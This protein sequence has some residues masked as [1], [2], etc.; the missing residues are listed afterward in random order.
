M[1]VTRNIKDAN[2]NW[3]NCYEDDIIT[4]KIISEGESFVV[5]LCLSIMPLF[6]SINNNC[7]QS[8][9]LNL[10]RPVVW[11]RGRW[12]VESSWQL[13]PLSATHR[14]LAKIKSLL[15][16]KKRDSTFIS[17][18]LSWHFA[19]NYYR[20]IRVPAVSR[21]DDSTC[22]YLRSLIQLKIL[23]FT[24]FL[25]SKEMRSR[26]NVT[27]LFNSANSDVQMSV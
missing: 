10:T 5:L 1:F 20:L 23:T 21:E 15:K 16:F 11:E 4:S 14:A 19:K 7:F 25:K 12:E 3:Q 26:L 8:F 6:Y 9:A 17:Y 18:E 24:S 13:V 22:S 2:I 27:Y